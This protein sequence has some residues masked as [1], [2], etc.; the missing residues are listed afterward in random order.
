MKNI[1]ILAL[2]AILSFSTTNTYAA[3]D[4]ATTKFG[5]AVGVKTQLCMNQVVL[6]VGYAVPCSLFGE[7][8]L[9]DWFGI[10]LSAV[11][12]RALVWGLVQKE[13]HKFEW[14]WGYFQE[15]INRIRSIK[16][17][18]ILHL[19]EFPLAFRFYPGSD[20]QF[21][22]FI[23]PEITFLLKA[24]RK[25]RATGKKT[26]MDLSSPNK[27]K[28]YMSWMNFGFDYETES[29][30]Q[31]GTQGLGFHLGYNFNKLLS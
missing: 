27:R 20:R 5:I 24:S 13:G 12:S 25:S 10:R 14:S 6:G 9:A 8:K 17:P 4:E 2:A 1:K 21:C 16:E 7:Y 31:L 11:H 22:L 30:F 26:P 28:V 15:F 19:L 18:V 29:G 3:E 23:A